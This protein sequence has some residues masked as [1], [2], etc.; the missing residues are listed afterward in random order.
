VSQQRKCSPNRL[1]IK[2]AAL[3]DNTSQNAAHYLV[4]LNSSYN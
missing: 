2:A 1:S 3:A 4:S